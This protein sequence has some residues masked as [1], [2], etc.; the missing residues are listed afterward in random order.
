MMNHLSRK[1]KDSTPAVDFQLPGRRE[2]QIL[3]ILWKK[4]PLSVQQV[5]SMLP[6]DS[7]LAYTTV[8][9]ILDQL[10]RKRLV[11]RTRTG[12]AYFYRPSHDPETVHRALAANFVADFFDGDVP[13]ALDALRWLEGAATSVP[14]RQAVSPDP[15]KD[16]P[17]TSAAQPTADAD[18]EP[19]PEWGEDEVYLL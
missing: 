19:E 8:M 4:Q 12:R 6:V 1:S 11:R 5:R 13:R 10:H 7:S 14:S 17:T 9:T 15:A 16:A 18:A 3:C 2:F